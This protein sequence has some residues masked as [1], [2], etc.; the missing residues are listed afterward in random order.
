MKSL[1]LICVSVLAITRLTAQS[2]GPL[3]GGTF[4][5]ASLSGSDQSWINVGNATTSDNVYASFADLIDIA[6][7]HT[8]YLVAT[9]FGFS[10]PVNTVITGVLVEIERSDPN[11]KTSD[12]SIRL[13]KGGTI[14]GADRSSGTLYPTTDAYGSYGGCGDL[15]ASAL[16]AADVNASNFG[17]AVAAQRFFAG[18]LGGPTQGRIDHIRIT[19]CY[20]I[21]TLPVVLIDFSSKKIMGSL[22]LNWKTSSE[23]NMNHYEIERSANGRDFAS[24]GTIASRDQFN[25]NNYSFEDNNPLKGISYYRLKMVGNTGDVKYSKIISVQF[26]TGNLISLYP[27]PWQKDKPL[28]I[29]NPNKEKLT[30]QFFNE[31]GQAIGITTTSSDLVPTNSLTYIHSWATYKIFNEQLQLLGTGRLIMK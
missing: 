12:Y 25:Q 1:M 31:N 4:S 28:N 21:V 11:F 6:G 23:I 22:E 9:N 26:S 5:N 24:I 20:T 3:S 18:A 15:W 27:I 14:S 16:T 7:A 2:Q 13:V 30:I 8:D 29:T 17:V 19:V 10:I